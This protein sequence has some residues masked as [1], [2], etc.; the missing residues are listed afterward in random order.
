MSPYHCQCRPD[1]YTVLQSK[2]HAK[3]ETSCLC[4]QGMVGLGKSLEV[5]NLTDSSHIHTCININVLL[6]H[7]E[8]HE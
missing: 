1:H 7:Y 5:V 2:I 8:N 3:N 6:A 4:V